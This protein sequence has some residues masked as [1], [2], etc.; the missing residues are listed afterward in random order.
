MPRFRDNAVYS[1]IIL[2]KW[3][4]MTAAIEI[5]TLRIYVG[6]ATPTEKAK[7]NRTEQNSKHIYY[8]SLHREIDYIWF[9]YDFGQFRYIVQTT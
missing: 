1:S 3:Q 8:F 2:D 9:N 4:E 7:Q 5:Q 6:A